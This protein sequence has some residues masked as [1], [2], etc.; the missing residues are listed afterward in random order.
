MQALLLSVRQRWGAPPLP[1]YPSGTKARAVCR[2]I[3]SSCATTISVAS[4]RSPS[5]AEPNPPTPWTAASVH[6]ITATTQTAVIARSESGCGTGSPAVTCRTRASTASRC[7]SE[8]AT[9]MPTHPAS[10]SAANAAR[11]GGRNA[12]SALCRMS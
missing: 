6:A 7:S 1:P 10:S 8:P 3:L 12:P 11:T 2:A 9:V 4:S 5:A